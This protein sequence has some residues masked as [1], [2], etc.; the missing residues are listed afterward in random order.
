MSPSIRPVS[1]FAIT[2]NHLQHFAA[3]LIVSS[4]TLLGNVDIFS[5]FFFEYINIIASRWLNWVLW[6]NQSTIWRFNVQFEA[7][8][9]M[10]YL[11]LCIDICLVYVWQSLPLLFFFSLNFN[12]DTHSWACNGCPIA[13]RSPP[14]R[15]SRMIRNSGCPWISL[16]IWTNMLYS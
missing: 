14:S 15:Y 8:S 5:C 7:W 11:S 13:C 6:G 2:C 12:H 3:L 10:W 1:T 9:W 16:S 4:F